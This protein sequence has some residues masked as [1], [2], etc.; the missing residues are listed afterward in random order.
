M[1]ETNQF[2]LFLR[3]ARIF[4]LIFVH[5]LVIIIIINLEFFWE[6]FFISFVIESFPILYSHLFTRAIETYFQN[7][8]PLIFFFYISIIETN[9]F[10]L[11]ESAF[12]N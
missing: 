6:K 2:F 11:G 3:R 4:E 12:S 7:L 5:V 9:Q 8:S 10:F 1:T